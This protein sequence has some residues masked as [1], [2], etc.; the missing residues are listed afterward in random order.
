[1]RILRNPGILL[2]QFILPTFQICLFCWAI[3]RDLTGINVAVVNNDTG[4]GMCYSSELCVCVIVVSY[5]CV[6]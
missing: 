6:L 2:F 4:L 5:V 3:G 1:M